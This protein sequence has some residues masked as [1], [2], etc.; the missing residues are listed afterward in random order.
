MFLSAISCHPLRPIC[1][2]GVRAASNF[3]FLMLTSHHVAQGQ[4]TE[5]CQWTIDLGA[6]PSFQQNANSP[7][8]NGFYTGASAFTFV[9]SC[10]DAHGRPRGEQENI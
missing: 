7:N 2:G 9:F 8:S 10:A 4:I 5:L 6:L 3:V 1:H